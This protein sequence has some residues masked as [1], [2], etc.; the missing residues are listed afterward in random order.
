MVVFILAQVFFRYVLGNALAWPEEEAPVP[1]A[2]VRRADDCTAYRRG[3]LWP[4]T[5]CACC[6]R[7]WWRHLLTLVL[8]GLSMA[9]PVEGLP[10]RLGPR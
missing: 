7:G 10:H 2:V 1:D 9:D 6:C 3:G 8:A 5:C 4:S